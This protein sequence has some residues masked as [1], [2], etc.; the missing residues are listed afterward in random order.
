MSNEEKKDQ[1]PR[2]EAPSQRP[3]EELRNNPGRTPGKAEGEENPGEQSSNS[4][5]K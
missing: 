1:S 4:G 2:S 3:A 5:G